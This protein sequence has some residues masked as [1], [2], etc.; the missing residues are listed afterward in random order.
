[1]QI[2]PYFCA[3]LFMRRYIIQRVILAIPTLLLISVVVFWLGQR[4]AVDPLSM[5][6]A[7]AYTAPSMDPLLEADHYRR[8][9]Q[10]FHLDKPLFYLS[11]LPDCYP[12]SLHLIFPYH[13]RERMAH[14]AR[15]CGDWEPVVAYDRELSKLV[16][17]L[18]L[19][20]DTL[21]R[22]A[23]FNGALSDLLNADDQRTALERLDSLTR[24][25]RV[26]EVEERMDT[27]RL[28]L[29]ALTPVSGWGWPKVY[30]YGLDNQYH[31]WLTGK[32][33]KER[34]SSWDR[35][36]YSLRV[37]LLVNGLAIVFALLAGISL[38]VWMTSLR[39]RWLDR[40]SRVVLVSS[41]VIPI[42]VIACVLRYLFATPG[43][44]L[45]LSTI[46][47]VGTSLYDPAQQS[48]FEWAGLNWGRL[49]LP[50]VTLWLHYTALI[51]LQMRAG[52]LGVM[53]AE[54]IRTA[55]ARG[56]SSWR[57]RWV[58]AV[59]N[60]L[61][62][63]ISIMG[64]LLPGAVSGSIITELIFN[65][66]GLG[67]ATVDAVLTGDYPVM[68]SIVLLTSVLT[69]TGNLL[70]DILYAWLDPRVRLGVSS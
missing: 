5:R 31:H 33:A 14:F 40:L 57:I 35:I 62:P 9:A 3:L 44:G 38:G 41:Y 37:T 2:L 28:C 10:S 20:F 32:F 19:V 65:I 49:I 45:Y 60:A 6:G 18:E 7:V 68:M 69:I 36:R 30:W 64:G 55:R 1:M 25:V 29:G 51:A 47:G 22:S 63:I 27:L 11:V 8:Q 66:N 17:Q 58:H 54:Y 16:R 50:L 56:L 13:R 21:E 70:V 46:G 12:D 48:F 52:L 24:I 59:P 4:A 61:F 34:G 67:H 43:H 15:S 26:Q 23:G 39:V 42:I 53:G